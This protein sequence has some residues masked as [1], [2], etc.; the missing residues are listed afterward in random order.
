MIRTLF[1][2][3]HSECQ[4]WQI[5]NHEICFECYVKSLAT[6]KYAWLIEICLS[7]K[8]RRRF[9]AGAIDVSAGRQLR[10]QQ[11][12]FSGARRRLLVLNGKFSLLMILIRCAFHAN[13]KQCVFLSPLLSCPPF[14]ENYSLPFSQ[15]IDIS[16]SSLYTINFIFKYSSRSCVVFSAILLF[17]ISLFF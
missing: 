17:V 1:H 12:T 6:V 13:L 14:L 2:C 3:S 9:G 10:I 15:F 11:S 5:A 16:L 4:C 8:G 7:F